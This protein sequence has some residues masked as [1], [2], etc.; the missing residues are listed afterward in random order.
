MLTSSPVSASLPVVDLERAKKFYQ[1]TL[2]LKLAEE[3][4]TKLILASSAR[5]RIS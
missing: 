2:G 3:V 1:D 4:G 5:D